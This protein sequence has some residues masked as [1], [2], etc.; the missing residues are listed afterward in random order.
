[1]KTYRNWTSDGQVSVEA[2]GAQVEDGSCA[3]P[4][5]NGQPD[6]APDLTENPQIEHFQGG[7]EGQDGHA[8]RQVS[9]GQRHDKQ[10]GDRP[11]SG[12]EKD[13]QNH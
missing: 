2:D 10:I 9:H 4:H 12:V 3:H 6:G 5:V 8:H 1:M 13:G 7:A 11:Q